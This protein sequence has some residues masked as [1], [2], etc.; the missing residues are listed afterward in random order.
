M[1]TFVMM[2]MMIMM[3][4]PQNIGKPHRSFIFWTVFVQSG[5]IDDFKTIGFSG[6][7]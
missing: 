7:F 5:N 4:N 3:G 6:N 1:A 2:M